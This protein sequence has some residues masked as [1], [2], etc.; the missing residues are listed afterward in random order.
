MGMIGR[1]AK[2]EARSKR[3][4]ANKQAK[5]QVNEERKRLTRP[6]LLALQGLR[7]GEVRCGAGALET[8]QRIGLEG[9]GRA[10][11]VSVRAEEADDVA[12]IA[13]YSRIH[14]SSKVKSSFH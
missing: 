6:T 11:A 14:P 3:E 4:N 10:D 7:G 12:F 9:L 8:L 13:S 1:S 5:M 2:H